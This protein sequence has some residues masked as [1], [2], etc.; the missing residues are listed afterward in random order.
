MP[1][2]YSFQIESSKNAW[3]APKIITRA[4]F[5]RRFAPHYVGVLFDP[6]YPVT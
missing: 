6:A 5:F 1:T 3:D 2:P 4:F